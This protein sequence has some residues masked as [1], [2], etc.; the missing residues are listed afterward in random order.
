MTVTR[1]SD[2][3]DCREIQNDR[4]ESNETDRHNNRLNKR[5]DSN[6][7]R[8]LDKTD[9]RDFQNYRQKSNETDRHKN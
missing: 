7:T 8:H 4:Q 2:K 5:R 6:E 3:T 9:S 1:H